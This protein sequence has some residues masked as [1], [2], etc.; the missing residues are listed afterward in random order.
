LRSGSRPAVIASI[1]QPAYLPWMGYFDKIVRSDLFIFMDNVQFQKNS[2]QNRNRIRTK[3]GPVWLTVPIET[4]ESLF[5]TTLAET[6]I[7]NR[8][9]WRSKHAT[10]LRM[11]YGRAVNFS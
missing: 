11:N 1:H 2:F 6:R 8:S 7:D 3:S 10:A 9:N 4:S 5:T